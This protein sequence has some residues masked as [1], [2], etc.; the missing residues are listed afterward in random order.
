MAGITITVVGNMVT[1][2]EFAVLDSGR[3]RASFRV[4]ANDSWYDRER[5]SWVNGPTS[6]F[7]VTCW[8]RVAENASDCLGKGM[9][10]VVMGELRQHEV[11]RELSG[12]GEPG[13]SGTFR[14]VYCDITARN[15]GLDLS[16]C[17]ARF[18][19]APVGPQSRTAEDAGSAAPGDAGG[20]RAA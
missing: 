11:V 9:P 2:V 20:E 16:R 13:S 5:K 6:Y 10:V 1:D 7:H 12:G 17:R 3:R 14:T 19:R 18:E 4:A 15:L 8:E